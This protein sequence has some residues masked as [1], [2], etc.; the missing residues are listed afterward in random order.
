MSETL[1][2]TAARRIALRAQGMGAARRSRMP[3]PAA[4][5]NAMLRALQHTHL[6]Q[7]DSVN[8]FAHAAPTASPCPT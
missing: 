8:V 4:S 5:R 6:F 2:W 3:Q 7:I 1:S